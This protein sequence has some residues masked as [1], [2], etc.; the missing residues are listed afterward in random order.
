MSE[1]HGTIDP[2]T[3]E[4]LNHRLLSITEEMGIQYMRCSGSNVLITGNDAA[5]AIMQPDGALVSV[6]PY[7][8]TQGNVLPMIVESTQRL[9]G[10]VGI[11]DGDIFICNDPYLGA[12]HQ[13]DFATVSPIYWQGEL[14]GWL[15]AS[16]HQLDTGGMDPGGFSIKATD[17]HQEGLRM[18]PVKLVDRGEMREDVLRWIMN[19]VR[20]PIVGLDVKGQVA[21]LNSGRQRILDL[22]GKWGVDTV[23]SVM[24]MSIDYSRGKLQERL[25]ELPDGVWR[26]VQYIDHD[27]HGTDI[28]Q[29]VCT[30]RKQGE[31]LEFD[32][33]GTSP[34]AK[35]L[36]NSTYSG[37]QA[38]VLS[39]VYINLC[40]DIPWNRGVRDCID[41]R[42]KEGTVNNCAYPA[43]CA[44]A[45]I[46]A[47]IVTIDASWRCLSQLLLAS[48]R[49]REQAMAVWSGTSM[50][51]IF[52]GTSQHGFPFA[53]TE[54]SH[55][56]GG[57]GARTYDDGVDTAGIVFNTTP[58]MPNIEDQE[59]EYPVLYLFRRHL[60]DSGGPGRYRGGRSAELAY[61]AH[62]APDD[63]LEGLF[64]GTGAEMPNA[65]GIGGGMPG[66]AIRVA[67]ILE[68]DVAERIGKGQALPAS[69]QDIDGRF[70]L[71]APKHSRS[72]MKLGDVWYHSWQA[73][74]GYGDPLK[75]D[76]DRVAQDVTRG[77]VSPQ[78]ATEI[79]GI[80]LNG[81]ACDH[82]ATRL[83]R[84]EI[85]AT[86]LATAVKPDPG[87]AMITFKGTGRRTLDALVV[88]F[89]ADTVACS[90]CGHVHC[91]PAEN[92]LPHLREACTPL[93]AAGPV[94]GE[95]YD[96]GR[97][98][99]RQLCCSGCGT[100]VDVQVA[101]NGAPRPFFR[102]ENW[103][104]PSALHQE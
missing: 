66:A 21:A 42:T 63:R 8:V 27:G 73:G 88:D 71:L 86:R 4:V 43:P 6:G 99:L 18:P 1:Q 29:I 31:G 67:R 26:E 11:H 98:R 79:Y 102:I 95:D 3:F 23:K 56:G 91:T 40:W 96:V 9:S 80:S 32:F 16:G 19:Q 5:T 70:E 28:Y 61:T 54:M 76:G 50:A 49:Y 10:D 62:H 64:A 51:P 60:R 52:A 15:G 48:E 78:A 12:I 77:V 103:T 104:S 85:R 39:A 74:G 58:N 25:R 34:N 14:I 94:R 37:L 100:L 41:L 72:P 82:A 38:A 92:L 36:I 24:R 53:A 87:D 2:V 45:T 20:D 75:R 55:F 101:L 65:I 93:Q 69:L 33:D 30:L 7:I 83:R 57:G 90:D 46:S 97:F 35:G 81:P 44:M 89:E 17:V 22:I 13:P 68:T 84:D 59:S 47:V